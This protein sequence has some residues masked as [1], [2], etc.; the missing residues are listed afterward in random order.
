MDLEEVELAAVGQAINFAIGI[1]ERDIILE[2]DLASFFL[3]SCDLRKKIIHARSCGGGSNI[4][5]ES[6]QTM[7]GKAVLGERQISI[8]IYWLDL[9]IDWLNTDVMNMNSI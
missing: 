5:N 1:G 3:T 4:K 6:A 2:G 8:R 9:L 7:E